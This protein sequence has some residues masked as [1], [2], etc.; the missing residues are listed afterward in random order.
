[1]LL[2]SVGSISFAQNK[3]T[4][5]ASALRDA[6]ITSEATLNLDFETVFKH[7]YPSIIDVMGGKEKALELLKTAF[8]TMKSQGLVF[9]KAEVKQVSDIVFEDEQ[10]R[11]YVEGF[12][13]MKMRNLRIKSKSYLLGIYN[14]DEDIWY[15]LEAEKL[16]NE[17]LINM[18][19]PNFKTSL[20]IPDDEMTTEEI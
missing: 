15:F 3:E 19:L 2:I 9:E 1:M 13:Q 12:N 6:K 7:T 8:D 10:Y 11:C 4:L 18:I 20:N 17:A 14:A 16:K 5:K